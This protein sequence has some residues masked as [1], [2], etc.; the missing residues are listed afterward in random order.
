MRSSSKKQWISLE[1]NHQQNLMMKHRV[2]DWLISHPESNPTLDE[3][4]QIAAMSS[5][6][7]TRVFRRVTGI[8]LKEFS[9]RVKVEIAGRLLQRRDLTVDAIAERCGFRDSRQLRRIWL[10][11]HGTSLAAQRR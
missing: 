8:T 6:N 11:H 2:Q 3:L 9:S 10:K 1:L 5:R 4:G 7:L